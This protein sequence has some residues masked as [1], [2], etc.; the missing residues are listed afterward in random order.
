MSQNL[1]T[2]PHPPIEWI[3]KIDVEH[4][5]ALCSTSGDSTLYNLLLVFTLQLY[6]PGFRLQAIP[7]PVAVQLAIC[8]EHPVAREHQRH[9]VG[10]L[11]AADGA[12]RAWLAQALG[13]LAV[14]AHFP[15]WDFKRCVQS[16]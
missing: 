9:W 5:N 10:G 14:R 7:G 8:A 4:R 11:C 12:R 2:A 1:L 15:V 13:N 16:F 3:I 6:Q